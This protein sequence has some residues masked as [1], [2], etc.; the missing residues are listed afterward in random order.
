MRIWTHSVSCANRGDANFFLKS[1]VVSPI[2]LDLDSKRQATVSFGNKC[3]KPPSTSDSSYEHFPL[4]FLSSF[5]LLVER[6]LSPVILY[7]L[8]ELERLPF[9]RMPDFEEFFQTNSTATTGYTSLTS[10]G[11]Q[12]KSAGTAP[13]T[14]SNV[15]ASNGASAA[16]TNPSSYIEDPYNILSAASSRLASQGKWNF[17][18]HKFI[19]IW[20]EECVWASNAKQNISRRW[21]C[22]SSSCLNVCSIC[23]D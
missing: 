18:R 22:T 6:V 4:S 20:V 3:A 17:F 1:T 8:S 13:S 15:V 19:M 7:L 10:I 14:V 12:I 5:L 23:F 9:I 2:V 11:D 21:R 16:T